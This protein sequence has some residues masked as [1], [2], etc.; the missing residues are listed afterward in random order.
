MIKDVLEQTSAQGSK[1]GTLESKVSHMVSMVAH[2]KPSTFHNVVRKSQEALSSFVEHQE[3]EEMNETEDSD[4]VFE[5]D[6]GNH[7]WSIFFFSI[8]NLCL[9]CILLSWHKVYWVLFKADFGSF[10]MLIIEGV[11]VALLFIILKW[12][13]FH[14]IY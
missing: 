5:M 8:L 3:I 7:I 9:D 6:L 1:F 2:W 13:L 11:V 4:E 10:A 12:F 14:G